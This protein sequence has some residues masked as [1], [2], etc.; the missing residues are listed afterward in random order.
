MKFQIFEDK[1]GEYRWRLLAGNSE[2]IAVGEGY[3]QK[4]DCVACVKLVKNCGDAVV[5]DQTI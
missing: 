3:K 2:I 1:V 5:E 4:A